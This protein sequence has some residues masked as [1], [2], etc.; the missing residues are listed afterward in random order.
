M[1]RETVIVRSILDYINAQPTGVAEKLQG[2]ASASGKAD[3][4]ACYRG[5][6]VRIEVKTPDHNNKAS[7][8]QSI[9]L[10]RWQAAGA[11]CTVAYSLQDVKNLLESIDAYDDAKNRLDQD[12]IEQKMKAL[13]F[14]L[15]A[16]GDNFVEYQSK[17][18]P[19]EII[20]F[21]LDKNHVMTNIYT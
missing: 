3:V 13:S 17:N 8:K 11:F 20:G 7:K 18:F 19:G 21:E 9:N 16:S 5:Y 12:W 15:Y 6:C 14:K 4:N 2:S 1:P 10:K